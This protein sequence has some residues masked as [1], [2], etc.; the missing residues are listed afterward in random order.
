[1]FSFKSGFCFGGILLWNFT[2]ATEPMF[3]CTSMCFASHYQKILLLPCYNHLHLHAQNKHIK[4]WPW[5]A[6]LLV[7]PCISLNKVSQRRKDY[8]LLGN[9]SMWHVRAKN[10]TVNSPKQKT[11]GKR[12]TKTKGKRDKNKFWLPEVT[13]QGNI[14]IYRVM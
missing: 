2:C 3:V 4:Q 1:M 8:N 11:Q 14:T 9:P 7:F 13:I 6:D 10:T 5:T 12:W